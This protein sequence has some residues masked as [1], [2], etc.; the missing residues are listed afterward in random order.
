MQRVARPF[1]GLVL[2]VLAACSD[3][4]NGAFG[5]R[6]VDLNVGGTPL[7]V[8]V[9]D[10]QESLSN[11]L[12]YRSALPDGQGMLFILGPARQASFWM[13]NTKIPLSIG[14]I[15]GN[16]I[17]REEHDMQPFDERTIRSASNEICY[18]LEVNQGWFQKHHIDSGI[19][20]TGIPR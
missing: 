4:Q 9:A 15:D 19:K 17:L 18:A 13:K 3:A 12:M 5:L 14:Y 8:E 6:T 20:I 7:K 16:A 10:T 11:G 2:F 1:L